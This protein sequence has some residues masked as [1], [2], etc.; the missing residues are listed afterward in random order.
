MADANFNELALKGRIDELSKLLDSRDPMLA[1][2]LREIHKLCKESEEL[3]HL[4]SDEEIRTWMRAQKLHVGVQLVREITEKKA[5]RARVPK[6]T[7]DD[8]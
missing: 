7:A 2:H 1:V 4:L 3:V 5:S 6:A 8:F